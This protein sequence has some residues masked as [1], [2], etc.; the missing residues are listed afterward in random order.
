MEFNNPQNITEMH[1][2]AVLMTSSS[3]IGVYW[4]SNARLSPENL[5]TVSHITLAPVWSH[6]CHSCSHRSFVKA[7]L[8]KAIEGW[9][10]IFFAYRCISMRTH[11]SSTTSVTIGYIKNYNFIYTTIIVSPIS[12]MQLTR[13]SYKSVVTLWCFLPWWPFAEKGIEMCASGIFGGRTCVFLCL[14]LLRL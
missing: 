2:Q 10:F 8:H 12:N 4:W 1:F 7:W 9:T 11:W 14:T 3:V 5:E 6:Q 13:R